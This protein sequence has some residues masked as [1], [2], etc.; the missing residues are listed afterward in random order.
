[1][2]G[3]NKG[4]HTTEIKRKKKLIVHETRKLYFPCAYCVA[5]TYLT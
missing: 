5:I 1:M 2:C 4:V 3:T